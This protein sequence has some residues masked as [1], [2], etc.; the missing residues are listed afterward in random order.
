M[1]PVCSAAAE[2]FLG[3][4]STGGLAIVTT[5]SK[6]S[7]SCLHPLAEGDEGLLLGELGVDSPVL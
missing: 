1:Y 6:L 4:I 7:I 3:N 2:G 5:S